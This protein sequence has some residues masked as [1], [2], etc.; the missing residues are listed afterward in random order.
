MSQKKRKI[1]TVLNNRRTLLFLKLITSHKT[2][3]QRKREKQ[4]DLRKQIQFRAN[5]EVTLSMIS[6]YQLI[7][8]YD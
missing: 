6:V 5:F 4:N 1:I 8:C 2:R 3:S 7:C